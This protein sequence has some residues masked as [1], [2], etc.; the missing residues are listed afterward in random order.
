[1]M[2][3]VHFENIK[4]NLTKEVFPN[5]FKIMKAPIT[6][7]VSSATC[8]RSFSSMMNM[9]QHICPSLYD[10]GPIYKFSNFEY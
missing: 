4:K 10:S 2:K 3:E 9:D 6:L 5:L 8:E 1:M 7:P